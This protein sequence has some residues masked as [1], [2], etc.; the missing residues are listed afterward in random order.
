MITSGVQRAAPPQSTAE[1]QSADESN[2]PYESEQVRQLN[3]QL[4]TLAQRD[5]EAFKEAL[6]QAFGGKADSATL[7]AMLTQARQGNLTLPTVQ[8]VDAGTLG[9]NAMGA[10]SAED[11]GTIFL[12]RRLLSDPE[13]LQAVFT[14]E[15]GHHLDVMLGGPDAAGDE[16]AIFAQ[17]LLGEPPTPDQLIELRSENDA[18][19]VL[20][21]G[22]RLLVEFSIDEA[23]AG[24]DDT[25]VTSNTDNTGSTDSPSETQD[26]NV[27]NGGGAGT[28]AQGKSDPPSGPSDYGNNDP[29]PDA[30][31]NSGSGDGET[32]A[33]QSW[34]SRA[35]S[36]TRDAF[37]INEPSPE[38]L[39]S[40][41][42]ENGLTDTEREIYSLGGVLPTAEPG[43]QV[44]N[45]LKEG[46]AALSDAAGYAFNTF[47]GGYLFKSH[48]ER[49]RNSAEATAYALANPVE[50]LQRIRNMPNEIAQMRARGDEFG[51]LEM[52]RQLAALGLGLAPAGVAGLSRLRALDDKGR[53]LLNGETMPVGR[54]VPNRL[55]QDIAVNPVPPDRLKTTRPIGTSPAQNARVQQ[56]VADAIARGA[57][58]IRV[59]QQQVNAAGERVGKNRPDIQF[60]LNGQ[61]V[62]YEIDRS[63]SNR[64]PLHE[65]RIRANDPNAV[66]HLEEI[67]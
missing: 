26:R 45:F 62:Y 55:P 23:V 4:V 56:I 47:S 12:D 21:D 61:R 38:D 7:D 36:W 22:R 46:L 39:N 43:F 60:T 10:Y 50:T 54:S 11:G 20:V 51:A 35:V 25:E 3:A 18:G 16:G 24:K 17:T 53:A 52:E 27:D 6:S 58:D 59:D 42:R 49:F 15:T 2:T 9:P 8:F 44:F 67:D 28:D 32:N 34:F 65:D 14:E 66:V 19:L 5:P 63:T 30:P 57:R 29:E 64:G 41:T 37:G 13:Q 48:A 33:E 40:R 31:S 1:Y